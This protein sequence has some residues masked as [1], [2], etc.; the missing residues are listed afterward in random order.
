MSKQRSTMMGSGGSGGGNGAQ[1]K[2]GKRSLLGYEDPGAH[3]H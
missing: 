3:G 2:A 1:Q